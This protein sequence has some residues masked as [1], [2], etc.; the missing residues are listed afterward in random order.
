MSLDIFVPSVE[1]THERLKYTCFG[2]GL[3]RNGHSFE[4]D[5]TPYLPV[6][7]KNGKVNKGATS[8]KTAKPPDWWKA[9]CVFRG[10]PHNGTLTE[11]QAR[12]RA[13]PSSMTKILV[14][15]QEK[16]N[17]EWQSK[18]D[19]AQQE[20]E[21]KRDLRQ[22]KEEEEAT[23]ILKDTF[24]SEKRAP[25]AIV[26]KKDWEGMPGAA[27]SLG[28]EYKIMM[29]PTFDF[30]REDNDWIVVGKNERAVRAKISSLQ[31]E[32]DDRSAAKEKKIEAEAEAERKALAQ[33]IV[34]VAESSAKG[35]FWDVTGTWRINCLE[36]ESGWDEEELSLKIY[37]RDDKAGSRMFAEFDFGIISGWFQFEGRTAKKGAAIAGQ[38][39]KL[40]YDVEYDSEYS[41]QE[42]VN[43]AF[44]LTRN[45][46]PSS[47]QPT[48][49]YRWRGRE[50]GESEIQQGS[51]VSL[52]SVTFSGEGGCRLSGEFVCGYL[53]KCQFTGIKVK[54]ADSRHAREIPIDENWKGL[55][56]RAW[57]RECTSRW[58]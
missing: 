30:D 22:R 44:Y 13:G 51:D 5:L 15:L 53:N 1:V 35:G 28:L 19:V 43:D 26:I 39:R 52:C 33:K 47:K 9:Q 18:Y 57:D 48:W 23:R 36:I 3:R 38:K 7:F 54:M 4:S 31:Q 50:T 11:V 56:D 12:L 6:L 32:A 24:R 17:A 40:E 55:S 37:H 25:D 21:R 49:N 8:L 29:P 16:V 2:Y 20:E 41:D 27:T 14:A 46:K 58:H 42:E 34:E 10:L 45:D